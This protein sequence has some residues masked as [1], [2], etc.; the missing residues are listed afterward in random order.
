MPFVPFVPEEI[1]NPFMNTE[2]GWINILTIFL[3]LVNNF[4][5][6]YIYKT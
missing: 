4:L 6:S 1:A 5:V 2:S 3:W